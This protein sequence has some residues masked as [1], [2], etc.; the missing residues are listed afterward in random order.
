MFEQ[1]AFPVTFTYFGRCSR[2]QKQAPT[3]QCVKQQIGRKFQPAVFVSLLFYGGL[4]FVVIKTV[5]TFLESREA[6]TFVATGND[7]TCQISIIITIDSY[8]NEDSCQIEIQN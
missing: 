4:A 5:D 8:A 2:L 1:N 6:T 7:V 3:G